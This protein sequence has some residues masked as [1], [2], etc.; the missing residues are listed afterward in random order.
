MKKTKLIFH[1]LY[2]VITLFIFYFSIDILLNTEQYIAKIKFTSYIKLPRY[3]VLLL[4][5]L[6]I[7][8]IVEFGLERIHAYQIKDGI[9]DLKEEI[10]SLKS[11]LHDI[12]DKKNDDKEDEDEGDDDDNDKEDDDDD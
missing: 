2:V 4:L 12:E 5:F 10:L 8:M 6:S 11:R 3:A 7:L 9:S 1:I